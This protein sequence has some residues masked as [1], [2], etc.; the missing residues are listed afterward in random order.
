MTE[1]DMHRVNIRISK[2]LNEWL[3]EE[4]KRTGMAKSAIMMMATENYKRE[5]EAFA[6]MADIGTLVGEINKM[7]AHIDQRLNE[8]EKAVKRN[9]P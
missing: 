8:V 3:D 2:S 9:D 1:N 7:G 5:K 4:A 6:M